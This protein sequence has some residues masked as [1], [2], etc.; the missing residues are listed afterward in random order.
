MFYIN[1]NFDVIINLNNVEFKNVRKKMLDLLL[2]SVIDSDNAAVVICDLNSVIVYMNPAAV[3]RY[4]KDLTG[5]SLKDCHNAKSNEMI[6]RVLGWFQKS[7][8]NN[9]M[10]TYYNEKENKDVYMVALRDA[11]KNLIGYYE[12]HEYRNRETAKP[13][14]GI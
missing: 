11:D 9:I 3:S 5:K 2:K 6:D 4:H 14:M 1:T 10:Y 7:P 8:E 13:Y 12:K